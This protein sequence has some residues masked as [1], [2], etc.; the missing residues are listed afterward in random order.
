MGIIK[1]KRDTIVFFVVLM[2][3][4][5]MFGDYFLEYKGKK[6]FLAVIILSAV[7]AVLIDILLKKAGKNIW[8]QIVIISVLPM[9]FSGVS[10]VFNKPMISAGSQSIYYLYAIFFCTLYLIVQ[11]AVQ[12]VCSVTITDVKAFLVRHKVMLVLLLIAVILRIPYLDLL[13]RWDSGEYYFRLTLGVQHFEYTS[14]MDFVE[15]FSLCGHP[16]LVFCLIY[17]IGEILFPMRVVGVSIVSLILAVIALWCI[18][19]I[20]LRLLKG[21]T[22]QKAAVY[23]FVLSMAPLFYSTAMYFNPDYAMAIFLIFVIYS[24]VYRKPILAGVASLMCFQTKET[25]LVLVGG[26]V[27]GIFVQHFL[28]NK[29]KTFFKKLFTDWRLYFTLAAT[30][31]Q[32]A[33][34]QTIGGLSNWTQNANEEP[35]LRWDN[36]GENCLGWNPQYIWVRL[37]QQFILNFNWIVTA[38]IV[39]CI[40]LLILNRKKIKES[41]GKNHD[42]CGI[43]GAFTALLAFSSLYIT[44]SV[45]RYNVAGDIL[46]YLILFYMINRVDCEICSRKTDWFMKWGSY[47]FSAIFVVLI[48]G[49]CFFTID[50]MTR[51][52][53]QKLDAGNTEIYYV[54]KVENINQ[55]YYGDYLIYN[56]QYTYIDKAYDKLLA[57]VDFEPGK[58]DII[59]PESNGSFIVGNIPFYYLSWDTNLKRRVFYENENAIGMENYILIEQITSGELPKKR[60][61]SRAVL[62]CNP[63]WVHIDREKAVNALSKYY[64][65]SE[66]KTAKT[67]QGSIIYY[68]LTLKK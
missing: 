17:M 40:V 62:V 20:F 43:V 29:N 63:Y 26:L 7:I 56:T 60:L 21:I 18:Y 37:K 23:T 33:Y 5:V 54:G 30:M 41:I 47:I 34:S 53:F 11:Y 50:P 65:I 44:A 4:I 6:A 2:L 35:G 16:T 66:E 59:L 42:I 24:Y 8:Q 55:I 48:T 46:L 49:Q 31:L 39:V 22:P 19:K 64:E 27:I 10:I 13:P 51:A 28:E 9:I 3:S 52:F 14:F 38:V 25:G 32:F 1:K 58:V 12:W 61:R 68:E 36:Y 67:F 15:N 57:D 45:A